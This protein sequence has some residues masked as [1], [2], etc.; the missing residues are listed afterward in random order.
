M[1]SPN[2]CE[3]TANFDANGCPATRWLRA[4]PL[5]RRIG[6][7]LIR[8]LRSWFADDACITG[9]CD[10]RTPEIREVANLPLEDFRDPLQRRHSNR[11]RAPRAVVGGLSGEDAEAAVPPEP[12]PKPETENDNDTR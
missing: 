1:A 4:W 11:D 7:G 8:R 2:A 12:H 9:V 10:L 3:R 5:V 6:Q